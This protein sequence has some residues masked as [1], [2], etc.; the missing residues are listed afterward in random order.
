MSTIGMENLI[1]A[2]IDDIAAPG[3]NCYITY[4]GT[5]SGLDIR[6]TKIT[7]HP[8]K[9]PTTKMTQFSILGYDNDPEIQWSGIP[10][11]LATH[12][13]NSDPDFLSADTQA[14]IRN[15]QP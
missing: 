13:Y 11:F 3:V 9:L 7:Y 6:L 5:F 2:V 14:I 15:G 8:D 12:I 10:H 4:N 1:Q